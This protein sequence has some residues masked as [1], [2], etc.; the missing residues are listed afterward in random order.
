MLNSVYGYMAFGQPVFCNVLQ[1]WHLFF[2]GAWGKH[3]GGLSSLFF[4]LLSLFP[5]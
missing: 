3:K 4:K 1:K 2:C 5:R